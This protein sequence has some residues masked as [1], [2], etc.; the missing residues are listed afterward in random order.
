MGGL[1]EVNLFELITLYFF[2]PNGGTVQKLG[3]SL[4][5]RKGGLS[6]GIDRRTISVFGP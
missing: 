4:W 1:G 5:T 6:A 2:P 3:I